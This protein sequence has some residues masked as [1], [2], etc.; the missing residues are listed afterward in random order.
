MIENSSTKIEFSQVISKIAEE[1]WEFPPGGGL[2]A[3]YRLLTDVLAV[4]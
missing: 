1:R 4:A 3:K 2:Q